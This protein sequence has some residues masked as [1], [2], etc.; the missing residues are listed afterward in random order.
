[1]LFMETQWFVL[2][3][4]GY[5]EQQLAFFTS[6]TPAGWVY[7]RKLFEN[8]VP[9]HSSIFHKSDVASITPSGWACVMSVVMWQNPP[10]V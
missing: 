10:L 3:E 4:N 2:S 9:F 1:M 8:G 6:I 7:F 5:C